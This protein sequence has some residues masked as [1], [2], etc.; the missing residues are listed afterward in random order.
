LLGYRLCKTPARSWLRQHCDG[1]YM[2]L[3]M[4]TNAAALGYIRRF[5]D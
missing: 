4:S 2:V 3:Q 1:G 5:L